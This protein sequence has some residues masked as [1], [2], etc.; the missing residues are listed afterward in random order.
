MDKLDAA[1]MV[2]ELRE[3]V[4]ELKKALKEACE[5]CCA[6]GCETCQ[7]WRKLVGEE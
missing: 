2:M 5:Y 7:E 3:E 6:D 1:L 4:A